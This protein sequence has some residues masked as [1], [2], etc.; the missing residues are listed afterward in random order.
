MWEALY[1]GAI[2]VARKSPAMRAFQDLPIVFVE[3]LTA[4]NPDVLTERARGISSHSKAKLNLD[5]WKTQ[6]EREKQT[7]RAKGPV[8]MA[9]FLRAWFEEILRVAMRRS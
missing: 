3:D 9:E 7:L 6:M 2:P 5:S 4:I 1:C 8:S